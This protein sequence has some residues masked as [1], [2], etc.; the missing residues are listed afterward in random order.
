MHIKICGVK[1]LAIAEAAITA[2][3]HFIGLILDS[4]SKRAIDIKTA[5]LIA[6]KV[7]AMGAKPVAVFTDADAG[8]MEELCNKAAIQYVQL[9]GKKSREQHSLLPDTWHRI[10]ACPVSENG[11]LVPDDL[12]SLKKLIATRDFLLFDGVQAGSGKKF[13][14]DHFY[15]PYAMPWFLSGGLRKENVWEG[16]KRLRPNGVDVSSGVEDERGEKSIHLIQDFINQVIR[17]KA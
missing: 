16:I 13:S 10:Y 3:A 2:G 1:S 9:H 15:N 11:A 4:A 12:R 7:R 8:H 17:E 14:W 6:Q 5:C